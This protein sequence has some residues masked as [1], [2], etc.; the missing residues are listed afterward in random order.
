MII[1]TTVN[2]AKNTIVRRD[3]RMSLQCPKSAGCFAEPDDHDSHVVRR[4]TFEREPD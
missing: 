4:T 3:I 1:S 2:A